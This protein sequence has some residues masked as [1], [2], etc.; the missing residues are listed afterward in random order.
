M[1]T[2]TVETGTETS[3]QMPGGFCA[4]GFSNLNAA[5]IVCLLVDLVFQV[6]GP[7]EFVFAD[8]GSFSIISSVILNPFRRFLY[9]YFYPGLINHT[10]NSCTC[11]SLHGVSPSDWSTIQP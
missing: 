8:V 6:R 3:A 10:L 11:I 7:S 4:A 5:F 9:V 1:W 2:D